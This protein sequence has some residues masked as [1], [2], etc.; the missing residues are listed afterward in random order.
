MMGLECGG[1]GFTSRNFNVLKSPQ[2]VQSVALV[3]WKQRIGSI[4]SWEY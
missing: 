1:G 4:P 2:L 3:E